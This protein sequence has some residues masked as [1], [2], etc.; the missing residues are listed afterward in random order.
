M[1]EAELVVEDRVGEEVLAD[2]E[3]RGHQ[4]VR[5]GPWSLGRMSAVS[6]DPDTGVLRAA[7]NPRG[8][9]GYAAGR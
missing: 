1:T 3:R 5:S 4:V 2:L 7:A 6:R 9:Q 8:M